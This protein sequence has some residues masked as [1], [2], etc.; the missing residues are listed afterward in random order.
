M[1][2]ARNG[3]EAVGEGERDDARVVR[4][5][6]PQPRPRDARTRVAAV[7]LHRAPS[8]AVAFLGKGDFRSP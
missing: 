6:T 4:K 3:G 2:R 1:C 8:S 5:S 7:A